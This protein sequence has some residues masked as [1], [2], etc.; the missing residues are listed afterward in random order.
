MVVAVGVGVVVGVVV[1]VIGV[2]GILWVVVVLAVV[3][4]PRA[5]AARSETRISC[6][7]CADLAAT[8][9]VCADAE[10]KRCLAAAAA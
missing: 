1:G 10:N 6:M 4:V 3:L 9:R 8:L 7:M 5:R 2:C